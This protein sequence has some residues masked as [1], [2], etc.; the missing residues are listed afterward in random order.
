MLNAAKGMAMT[1][2]DL[3]SD[4]PLMQQVTQEFAAT[5]K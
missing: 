3:L 5:A 2:I 1:T 4:P